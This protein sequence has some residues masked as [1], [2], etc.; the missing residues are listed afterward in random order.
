MTSTFAVSCV[1]LLSSS[2]GRL[3]FV[4]PT[5]PRCC[6]R[7]RIA[8]LLYNN[9]SRQRK[10]IPSNPHLRRSQVKNW[11]E[12]ELPD[13]W[14]WVV[15]ILLNTHAGNDIRNQLRR[16]ARMSKTQSRANAD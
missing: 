10:V 11:E 14:G 13:R 8:V 15:L 1:C 12:N 3:R 16:S 6:Q 7:T 4:P 9:Q 2:L 5:C